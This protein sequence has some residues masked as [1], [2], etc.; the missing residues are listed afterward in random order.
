MTFSGTT[1]CGSCSVTCSTCATNPVAYGFALPGDPLYGFTYPN[2]KTRDMV[3]LAARGNIVIGDYTSHDFRHDVVSLLKPETSEN[4]QG[5]TQAYVVDSHDADLGYFNAGYDSQNRPLFNGNYDQPDKQGLDPGYKLNLTS[6]GSVSFAL[7]GQGNKI[8]RKFY[9][10]TL[11]D[12][13]FQKLL[14]S[15][16]NGVIDAADSALFNTTA[17]AKIDAVL[18]TN[19]ALAG[20][21]YASTLALNGAMVSRDE[22][23]NFGSNLVLNHDM[24]LSD[25]QAINDVALPFRITRPRLVTLKE[26]P[27]GGCSY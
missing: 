19:H 26:C 6:D 15:N 17:S 24:R 12:S 3:G 16:H 7:D 23:L 11:S 10:S 4:P 9:E 25:T 20:R 13:A 22:A 2:A 8:P 18:F 27:A 1:N 5:K 14:D 21:V